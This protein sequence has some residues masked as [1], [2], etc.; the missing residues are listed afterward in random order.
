LFFS[1]SVIFESVAWAF[2]S[3]RVWG[4]SIEGHST[5]H[6]KQL[7]EGLAKRLNDMIDLQVQLVGSE[8]RAPAGENGVCHL[9]NANVGLGVGRR[10]PANEFLGAH[11][12]HGGGAERSTSHIP[13]SKCPIA[14]RSQSLL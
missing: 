14:A 2:Q 11:G 9:E 1:L 12:K 13:V 7:D 8:E 10:E 3:Q 6:N 5:T 4:G